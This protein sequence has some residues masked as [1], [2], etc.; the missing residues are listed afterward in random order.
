MA[1]KK[2]LEKINWKKV[3]TIEEYLARGGE[4]TYCEPEESALKPHVMKPATGTSEHTMSLGNGELLFG[5][6]RKRKKKVK[7]EVTT[8]DFTK[9]LDD[10]KNGTFTKEEKK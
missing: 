1:R 8:E 10:A 9:M 3:E 4:I 7:P 5:E 2:Q 6:T